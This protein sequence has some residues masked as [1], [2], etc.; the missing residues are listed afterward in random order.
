MYRE[1]VLLKEFE[2]YDT[3]LADK[4]VLK[5]QEQ[6]DIDN[7][8]KECQEKLAVKKLEIEQILKKEREIQEE[9]QKTL[10]EANK[11]E[12]YLTRVLRKKIKRSKKKQKTESNR[13]SDEN[14]DE[15]SEESEDSYDSAEDGDDEIEVEDDI[16][17][18]DCDVS[19]FNRVLELRE[20]KLDSDDMLM[21]IQK[22]IEALRKEN[23][24][25]IK[26]EKVIHVSLK[27][28]EASIEDFQT[29]KQ[30]KLNELDVI[31][32]LRLHQLQYLE[33][34]ALPADLSSALVFVEDGLRVLKGRIKELHEEKIDIKK[35]HWELKKMHVSLVKSRK[36]KQ[37]K[38]EDL[39]RRAYEVQ[40][41]KFG[42]VIDLDKLE[43]MGV[44]KNA[45]ELREKL[46]KDDLRR[47]QELN[48]AQKEIDKRKER[49]DSVIKENTSRL[50]KIVELRET[51]IRLEESL[52]AGQSAVAAEY[53][54]P[55][56]KDIQER[57]RLLKLIHV[58]GN[59]IE[60]L[61]GE[62]EM[63]VRKPNNR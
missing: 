54:G 61:K 40:M 29:Q 60:E 28:T 6:Y 2:K 42:K 26:K 56:K 27:N 31:V 24:S 21:E 44:N 11:H 8:L 45:E 17:P 4:L 12:E 5:R 39:D 15:E 18:P 38:L 43:R 32:P 13:E 16:C 25:L 51:D 50:D 58:Q 57:E 34:N 49:L 30:Q 1:W 36:E 62:I 19:I 47:T 14:D 22:A 10:G 46:L 33:N 20:Q 3:D 52:N 37:R 48:Q 59:E 7:K 63:L 23:E 35:S 9:F 41:L 55:M 53:N